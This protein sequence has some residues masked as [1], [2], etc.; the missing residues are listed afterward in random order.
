[1]RNHF[2]ILAA[3]ISRELANLALL[4]E[5]LAPLLPD[6]PQANPGAAS[7][8]AIA[9][10][11]H[12]FYSGIE[13]VFRRIAQDVDGEVPRGDNWHMDLLQRMTIP[14]PDVRPA[15]VNTDLSETLVE[16]LRFRHLFR[17][18]YEFHLRW[19]KFSRLA[20][21]MAATLGQFQEELASFLRF[22]QDL[23]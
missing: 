10:I 22:L 11:L 4:Q 21:G 17:N 15:V 2:R 13:K 1:M 16:Y 20:R 14:I 12:D 18:V 9:S 23:R 3:E 6:D 8:R 7:V 5:E 19:D